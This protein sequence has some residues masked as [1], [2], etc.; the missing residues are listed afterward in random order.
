MY[1][2]NKVNSMKTYIKNK[3]EIEKL[4]GEKI[5]ASIQTHK[6]CIHFHLVDYFRNIKSET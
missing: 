1:L 4:E 2:V 6:P 3:E 5:Q